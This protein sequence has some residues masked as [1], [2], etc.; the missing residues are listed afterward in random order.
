MP[1]MVVPESPT[2]LSPKPMVV[3]PVSSPW[4]PSRPV[5]VEPLPE[6]RNDEVNEPKPDPEKT[7]PV[8]VQLVLNQAQATNLAGKVHA[9]ADSGASGDTGDRDSSGFVM[10][11]LS[12][13]NFQS[14]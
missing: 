5:V 13:E 2:E 1:I 10:I 4:A 3:E 6:L 7:N 14:S 12:S 9:N 8:P 11:D